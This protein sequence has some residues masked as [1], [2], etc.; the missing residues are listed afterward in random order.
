MS[1]HRTPIAPAKYRRDAE[2]LQR[3][4]PHHPRG[5]EEVD[6]HEDEGVPGVDEEDAGGVEGEDERE[7]ELRGVGEVE[8]EA[9]GG[10]DYGEEG[11]A[12]VCWGGGGVVGGLED[13]HWACGVAE[14]G[15]GGGGGGGEFAS[16]VEGGRGFV[17]GDR[18]E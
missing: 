16:L 9:E 8:G 3:L 11:G 7:E 17:G 13:G 14:L 5:V 6:A 12:P 4:D 1:R 10:G 18:C 15:G 2:R